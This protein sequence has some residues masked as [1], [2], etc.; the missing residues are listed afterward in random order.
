MYLIPDMAIPLF[1]TG[2]RAAGIHAVGAY[3]PYS[4][5]LELNSARP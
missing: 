1:V 4:N 2:K 5:R 3:F